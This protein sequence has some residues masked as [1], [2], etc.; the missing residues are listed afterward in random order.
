MRV[1]M[2]LLGLFGWQTTTATTDVPRQAEW[3]GALEFNDS[4]GLTVGPTIAH[5]TIADDGKVTG[6]WQ[7]TNKGRNSGTIEGTVTKDGKFKLRVSVFGGA[8]EARPDG[9]HETIA[10]ERCQGEGEFNGV[11]FA[12]G[13]IRLTS[14]RIAFDSEMKRAR[15]KDCQDVTGVVWTLQ[16]HTH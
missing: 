13:A 1:L 8:S 10:V 4:R 9:S 12:T 5:L 15:N 14:K 6:R 2:L 7:S 3:I 16:P 11:L